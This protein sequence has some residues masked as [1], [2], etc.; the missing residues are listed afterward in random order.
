[1]RRPAPD[2]DAAA[3]KRQRTA[4]S[5][6]GSVPTAAQQA[7]EAAA[8]GVTKRF[9][10]AA[11]EALL[12]GASC[13]LVTCALGRQMSATK[14]GLELIKRHLPPSTTCSL[15]KASCSGVVLV[16]LQQQ[17]AD[18]DEKSKASA[19]AVAAVVGEGE[20]EGGQRKSIDTV[21]VAA[22]ALADVESGAAPRCRFVE[23]IIPVQS[24]CEMQSQP[25]RAAAEALCS[26]FV[27]R[28][29]GGGADGG[30]AADSTPLQFAGE[31][32]PGLVAVTSPTLPLFSLNPY[33]PTHCYI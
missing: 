12:D 15:V 21:E 14:E 17:Q 11:P 33:M 2:F 9:N 13:L 25:L 29:L 6:S 7:E 26:G 20:G 31:L 32:F 28:L 19:A 8:V 1:M 10:Y 23:R 3:T 22:G 30:G 16:L 18:E 4:G 27:A 5:G 24:T